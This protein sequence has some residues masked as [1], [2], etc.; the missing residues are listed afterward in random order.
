MR[1]GVIFL[2][3]VYQKTLSPDRG[4]LRYLYT[5][6]THTCVFYPTCS[7]YMKGAI[8]KYG[9]RRGVGLGI[10]RIQRCSPFTTPQI[11]HVP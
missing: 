3:N 11:D 6:N 9:T 1:R 5:T 7:E 4:I 10:Q 2:I 8:Y